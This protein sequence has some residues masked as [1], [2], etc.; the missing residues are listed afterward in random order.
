[1]SLTAFVLR[2]VLFSCEFAVTQFAASLTSRWRSVARARQVCLMSLTAFV[3]SAHGFRRER[4]ITQFAAH[5]TTRSRRR[6]RQAGEMSPP[7]FVLCAVIHGRNHGVAYNASIRT[8]GG[9]RDSVPLRALVPSR[10]T[11]SLV[12]IVACVFFILNLSTKG[13]QHFPCPF[14]RDLSPDCTALHCTSFFDDLH[15][16]PRAHRVAARRTRAPP[17]TVVSQRHGARDY[18]W[19]R[20]RIAAMV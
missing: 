1:M 16:R 12:W 19:E 8:H 18:S 7:T 17:P 5:L 15:V 13:C 10:A 14:L 6:A 20:T 9:A 11:R 4:D 3:D 2:A